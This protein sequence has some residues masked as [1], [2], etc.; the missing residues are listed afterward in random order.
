M[1]E[2]E[3]HKLDTMNMVISLLK[4]IEHRDCKKPAQIIINSCITA[5]YQIT[6]NNNDKTEEQRDVDAL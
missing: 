6:Q 3:K 5:C 1:S 2:P 4:S